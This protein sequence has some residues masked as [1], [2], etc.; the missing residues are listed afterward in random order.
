MTPKP[1]H[2][3]SLKSEQ[4]GPREQDRLL[5]DRVPDP[6]NFV[7]DEVDDSPQLQK[8]LICLVDDEDIE[9]VSPCEGSLHRHDVGPEN[10]L[11]LVHQVVV[12]C[13]DGDLEADLALHL[14]HDSRDLALALTR[15]ELDEGG[16]IFGNLDPKRY[17]MLEGYRCEAAAVGL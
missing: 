17:V 2:S 7:V 16:K 15:A 12:S 1:W 6:C 9:E 13:H 10:L 4:N 5:A 11:V 8:A 14:C 3:I